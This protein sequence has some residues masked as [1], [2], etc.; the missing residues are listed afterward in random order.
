[1]R[2]FRQAAEMGRATE[3]LGLTENELDCIRG[4]TRA[5]AIWKLGDCSLLGHHNAPSIYTA[6]PTR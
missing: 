2:D 4:L 3:M 5:R 6:S 1:M